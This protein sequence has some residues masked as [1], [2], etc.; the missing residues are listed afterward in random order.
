MDGH[1][2]KMASASE[3]EIDP[4]YRHNAFELAKASNSE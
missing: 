4:G 3:H 1:P 2:Q